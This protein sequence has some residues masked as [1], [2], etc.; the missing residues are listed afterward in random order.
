MK[1]RSGSVGEANGVGTAFP[2]R[3]CRILRPGRVRESFWV[4]VFRAG[5]ARRDPVTMSILE[6]DP[7]LGGGDGGAL[8]GWTGCSTSSDGWEV[9]DLRGM[10]VGRLHRCVPDEADPGAATGRKS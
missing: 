2:L 1:N 9:P 8:P 4:V 6:G 7:L 3:R 5:G 10:V